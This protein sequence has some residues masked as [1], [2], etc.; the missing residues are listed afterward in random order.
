MPTLFLSFSLVLS[1]CTSLPR[2]DHIVDRGAW[3]R[4]TGQVVLGVGVLMYVCPSVRKMQSTLVIGQGAASRGAVAVRRTQN[5]MYMA[6][7]AA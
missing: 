3:V 5:I 4:P 2:C 7:R 6:A 1:L